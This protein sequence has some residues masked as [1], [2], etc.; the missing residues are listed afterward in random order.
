MIALARSRELLDN[1][2]VTGYYERLLARS[3]RMDKDYIFDRSF[4]M[5]RFRPNLTWERDGVT[6]NSLGMI[7]P[8]RSLMKPPG[9]RRVAL[10]GGSLSSGH[11]V[12]A[13]QTYAALLE[14]RLNADRPNG[15]GLRFEI[16]NFACIAYTLQQML[17]V[18][19]EDT[20]RFA[21]DVYLLD[22]NELDVFRQWDRH[23]VQLI[24][25]DIDAKYDFL[26]VILRQA[27]VSPQDDTLTLYG[28]LAPYRIPALRQ[29]LA[30]LKAN[31]V[32]QHAATIAVLLPAVEAAD[33]STRRVAWVRELVAPLGIPVVDALDSFDGFLNPA[34][35]AAFP[36]DV[37]PSAWGNALIFGNLYRKLRAEPE[38]WSALTGASGRP[39]ASADNPPAGAR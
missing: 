7:G 25:A 38:A 27:G 8:E 22:L 18:A 35:L 4:R 2:G 37:H 24:Q 16:L 39:D 33:L 36:G 28:K 29:T 5:F 10:L 21:P 15:P 34:P 6:T 3:G 1:P 12:P 30:G 23:L 26:R 32:R 19:L 11:M 9:V 31:A 14:D 17:D 20:P 13:G